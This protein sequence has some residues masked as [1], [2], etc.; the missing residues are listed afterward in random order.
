[1]ALDI[2]K[3]MKIYWILVIIRLLEG[4]WI[5]ITYES[6]YE[7]MGSAYF[8]PIAA[9]IVGALYIA[10][11]VNMIRLYNQLDN[12][13]KIEDWVLF[14]V[15]VQILSIIAWIIGIGVYNYLTASA[16]I[17]IILNLFFAIVGIHI[18][19]QKRK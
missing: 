8:S 3:E 13:E 19:M 17:G 7:L 12:W 5:F 4:L 10:W 6:F 15:M 16:I 9:R 18:I 1:L 14:G 11:L 2:E